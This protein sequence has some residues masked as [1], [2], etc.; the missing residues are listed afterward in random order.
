MEQLIIESYGKFLIRTMKHLIIPVL[1]S[2]LICGCSQNQETRFDSKEYPSKQSDISK[3]DNVYLLQ[4]SGGYSIEVVGLPSTQEMEV[5]I[6]AKNGT[7]KWMYLKAHK[8]K[9]AEVVSQKPGRWTANESNITITINGNSGEINEQYQ[10]KNGVFYNT[11]FPE[12]YLK[13]IKQ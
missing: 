11:Q 2:I 8:A 1:V 5:Y 10:K 9:G 3:E 7:A 6:L 12:R 4:H 13:L